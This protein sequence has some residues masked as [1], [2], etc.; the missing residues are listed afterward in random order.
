[1]DVSMT[2]FWD[3]RIHWLFPN[4]PWIWGGLHFLEELSVWFVSARND[5]IPY[6][7]NKWGTKRCPESPK[8]TRQRFST[9]TWPFKK[10]K[11]GGFQAKKTSKCC[12][13]QTWWFHRLPPYFA[14][15]RFATGH[16]LER[17]TRFL[18]TWWSWVWNWVYSELRKLMWTCDNKN[19]S[20]KEGCTYVYIYIISIF[21]SIFYILL[22]CHKLEYHPNPSVL[23]DVKNLPCHIEMIHSLYLCNNTAIP[24][25]LLITSAKY[26]LG[27][28]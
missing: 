13:Q 6:L 27:I 26:C 23:C 10:L 17:W 22:F 20:T 11:I 15:G 12:N 28:A 4:P 7:K 2:T 1:M 14:F 21:E 5:V 24:F 19:A 18:R 8:S 16:L 9:K 3:Q 25:V